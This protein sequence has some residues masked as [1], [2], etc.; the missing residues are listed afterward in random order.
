MESNAPQR[1]DLGWANGDETLMPR[2]WQCEKDGHDTGE[3]N[4]DQTH[5]GYDSLIY[6]DTCGYQ[7]HVDSSG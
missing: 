2:L 4:L 5:H 7:F 3:R 6:C 1:Q